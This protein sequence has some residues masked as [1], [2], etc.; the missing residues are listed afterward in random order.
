MESDEYTLVPGAERPWLDMAMDGYGTWGC[1]NV[2]EKAGVQLVDFDYWRMTQ[3]KRPNEALKLKTN[4]AQMESSR[5]VVTGVKITEIDS[6]S[7]SLQQRREMLGRPEL[8]RLSGQLGRKTSVVSL[9][10]STA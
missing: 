7:S 1:W 5:D 9:V 6:S 2:V 8:V 3:Q 4:P 10:W